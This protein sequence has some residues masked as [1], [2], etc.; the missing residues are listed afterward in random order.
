MDHQSEKP[1]RC[2]S[3]LRWSGRIF[4]PQFEGSPDW[5]LVH[6]PLYRRRRLG[7]LMPGG[8]GGSRGGYWERG[9]QICN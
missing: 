3:W 7:G 5:W 4:D 6:L 9:I 1:P 2:I 8:G